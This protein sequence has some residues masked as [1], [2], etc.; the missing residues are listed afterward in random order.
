[1]HASRE[2]GRA[3]T[4]KRKHE[5]QLDRDYSI[6][7]SKAHEGVEAYDKERA[8]HR[9]LHLHVC[10]LRKER[11]YDESTTGPDDRRQRPYAE[12]QRPES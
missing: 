10:E 1:M 2:G 7:G 6:E 4:C 8:G 9:R 11:D 12:E 5:T 3:Q